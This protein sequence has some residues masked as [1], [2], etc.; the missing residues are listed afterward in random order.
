MNETILSTRRKWYKIASLVMVLIFFS[1][2]SRNIFLR[3]PVVE[4]IYNPGRRVIRYELTAGIAP[5]IYE[6]MF[7]ELI[8]PELENR[9]Y[10]LELVDYTDGGGLNFALNKNEIDINIFQ[11]YGALLRLR[12]EHRLE[13]TAITEI[14]SL[15][16]DFIVIA[17]HT[18]SLTQPFVS[19][20]L[21]IVTSKEFLNA[22]GE[23]YPDLI[24]P[25][26]LVYSYGQ[27]PFEKGGDL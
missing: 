10:S 20:L 13:I 25:P 27:N 14:P 5:G 11:T 18:E 2:C 3:M 23:R 15:T 22:V 26:G 17:V 8:L 6:E 21:N 16:D 9:G 1:G 19:E 12:Y 24:V 4:D 7:L